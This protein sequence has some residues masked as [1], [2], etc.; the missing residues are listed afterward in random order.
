M[1][2]WSSWCPRSLLI[3]K[4]YKL[5][6]K[7]KSHFIYFYSQ[8]NFKISKLISIWPKRSFLVFKS[9]FY[10]ILKIECCVPF[11]WI[12]SWAI[13]CRSTSITF[14][15]NT[16]FQMDCH[17]QSGISVKTYPLCLWIMVDQILKYLSLMRPIFSTGNTFKYFRMSIFFENCLIQ[18]REILYLFKSKNW[19]RT[20]K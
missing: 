16:M 4:S 10:L 7:S 13:I 9:K 18:R 8:T 11:S 12:S 1:N 15:E 17:W 5:G 6:G 3:I 14:Y 20:K 2:T 19:L